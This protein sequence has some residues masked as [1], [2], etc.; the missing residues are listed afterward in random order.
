MRRFF[1]PLQ[2]LKQHSSRGVAQAQPTNLKKIPKFNPQNQNHLAQAI[3]EASMNQNKFMRKEYDRETFVK[4]FPRATAILNICKSYE[5]NEESIMGAIERNPDVL[6][7]D[8]SNISVILHQFQQLGFGRNAVSTIIS[9]YPHVL[10]YKEN[11]LS[12]T[13]DAYRKKH[14]GERF[15]IKL[16]VSYPLLFS[17]SD[18][19]IMNRL[20][21]INYLMQNR[22]SRTTNLLLRNPSLMCCD[23]KEVEEKYEYLYKTMRVVEKDISRSQALT[24]PLS[25]TILRHTFLDRAGVYVRP[26]L[27][28]EKKGLIDRKNPSL[29]DIVDTNDA[30]FARRVAKVSVAEF[31]VF[32]TLM[33]YEDELENDED[34]D[35]ELNLSSE[36]DAES[37]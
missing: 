16:L 23:W 27:K 11:D 14:F 18:E 13:M 34:D 30:E 25:H 8:L 26:T 20:S 28:D 19:E 4:Q 1:T 2:L 12:N 10:Q 35:S 22:I 36:F 7:F 29:A 33:H 5:L 32:K 15:I 9:Q 17:L 6:D 37:K 21:R 3:A 24:L 31:E